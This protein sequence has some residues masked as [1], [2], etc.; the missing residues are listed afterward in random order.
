MRSGEKYEASAQ[1]DGQ[2]VKLFIDATTGIIS[3]SEG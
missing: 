3:E 2:P 1:K